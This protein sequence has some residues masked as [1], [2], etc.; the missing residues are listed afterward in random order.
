MNTPIIITTK[1]KSSHSI[2]LSISLSHTE[3]YYFLAGAVAGAAGAAAGCAVLDAAG[4]VLEAAG[5]VLDAAGA[6]LVLPVPVVAVELLPL[7][8]EAGMLDVV[9]GAKLV[10]SDFLFFCMRYKIRIATIRT[11][12]TQKSGFFSMI[13][14]LILR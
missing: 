2:F 3:V 10:D 8:V 6:V 9:L 7:S 14:S 4:V 1:A 5:A 13:T 12:M 11:T